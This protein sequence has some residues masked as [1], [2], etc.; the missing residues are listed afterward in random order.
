MLPTPISEVPY[1]MVTV[2]NLQKE[3]EEQIRKEAAWVHE[4][5]RPGSRMAGTHWHSL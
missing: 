4:T 5:L 3:N 2:D 1:A